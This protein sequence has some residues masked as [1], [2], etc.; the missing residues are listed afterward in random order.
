M[1]IVDQYLFAKSHIIKEGFSEEIKWQDSLDTHNITESDLL[2]EVVWVILSSGMRESVVRKLFPKI[3]HAFY[4]LSDLSIILNNSKYCKDKALTIF[5]HEKK[6][7]SI[8]YIF[9]S[10]EKNGVK[11]FISQIKKYGVEFLQQYPFLGPATSYHLAKNLGF[12]VV[13][14]D[15][16]LLR[17]ANNTGFT[18]PT[19]LCTFISNNVGDPISVVDIVIWRYATLNPN[20]LK[21]FNN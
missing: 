2:C 9:K 19:E 12:Q 18:S 1:E 5:N 13:K 14:P 3:A 10:I 16:H 7:D 20:Y 6:I 15:R 11:S 21:L 8:I 4:D 17:V